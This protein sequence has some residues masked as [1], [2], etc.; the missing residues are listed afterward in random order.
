MMYIYE[1]EFFESEGYLIV[2]PFDMEGATQG[3]ELQEAVEMAAD[4][5]RTDIQ[6]RLMYNEPLPKPTFGNTPKEGGTVVVIAVEAGL[7]T[8]RRVSAS[9][10]ARL[11]NVSP[12]RVSHMIRDGLL[13]SFKDGYNVWVTMDSI[14]ARL[15]EPRKAGRPKKEAVA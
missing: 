3:R 5:L 15:R 7:D 2:Y 6:Y 13:T 11:L 8:I 12:A 1:F 9:E 14:E 10:A 4:W